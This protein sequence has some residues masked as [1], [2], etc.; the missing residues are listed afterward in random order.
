MALERHHA[1][2]TLLVCEFTESVAMEDAHAAQQVI[3]ALAAMGVQLSFD[4]FGTGYSSLAVL[5]QLRVHELKIDRL[6]VCDIAHD[7][8]AR[9]MVEA[10]LKLAHALGL[11]VV[12]EGVETREQR[13]VLVALG[14]DELQGFYFARPMLADA[15]EMHGLTEEGA[16]PM[17]FSPSVLMEG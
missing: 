15:L 2:P 1:D 6:F 11:K 16:E 8:R 5:R 7:M 10:V 14:C 4:D 13:D 17:P 9:E 3:D 12:A